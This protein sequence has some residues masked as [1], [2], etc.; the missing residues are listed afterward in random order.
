MEIVLYI[1]SLRLLIYSFIT[2]TK[3]YSTFAEEFTQWLRLA[4]QYKPEKRGGVC[5]H[6]SSEDAQCLKLMDK[7]LETKVYV[8]L[9]IATIYIMSSNRY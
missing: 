5:D 9:L 3:T 7:V 1:V 2:D 6:T 4:L 8:S